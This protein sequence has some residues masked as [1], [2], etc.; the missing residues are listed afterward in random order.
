MHV[1]LFF[2]IDRD[3]AVELIRVIFR[4]GRFGERDIDRAF[5]IERADDA[6]TE[7][8]R[9]TIILSIMIGDAGSFS[10]KRLRR[11]LL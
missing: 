4:L 11:W 8:Q 1:I 9:M 5:G 2:E 6:A 3:D 10:R 7:R